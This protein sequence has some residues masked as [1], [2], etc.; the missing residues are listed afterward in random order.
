MEPTKAKRVRIYF[1]EDDRWQGRPLH[2]ALVEL[3]QAEHA[4][5]ATVL[6]GSEGFGAE[7][8]LHVSSLV[9]VAAQLPV[10]VEWIDTP[11]Q[12]QRLLPQVLERVQHGLV[13]V[14]E[15]ELV[16]FEPPTVHALRRTATVATVMSREVST[17]EPVTPIRRVVEL[18]LGRTY[19]AVPVTEA[20]KPVGIITNTDLVERGGLGVR[21][22]LLRSLDTPEVHEIL[23]RLSGQNRVASEV[24]TRSPTTVRE[25]TSLVAAADLMA[26]RRLKRLPVIDADRRLVGMVSRL[27]LLR[28]A[29]AELPPT[30]AEPYEMGLA[31]NERLATVMRRDVPTVN[32][33]T[34]LPEVF[35]AVIATRLHRAFVVDGDR[36]V[37][38]LVSDAQLLERVT[39]TLRRS[40]LR[41]LM[42]R[43]PFVHPKEEPVGAHARGRTA[44]DVMTR[45][46]A[47]VGED[48]LLSQAIARM[49]RDGQKVL[50]VTDPD[51]RLAGIVD[52]ADLLHGLIPAG[53]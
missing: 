42:S 8:R 33:D 47:Q 11:E 4:R 36:R 13:T 7:G 41:S 52:R 50:A 27:D 38:G 1:N 2:R 19:R 26:R 43:L 25:N 40:A 39:P 21:L 15:T 29:A 23:E 9:D 45:S 12:V 28:C 18:M 17:V 31:G 5:G 24:M 51:G 30:A 3:L 10:V 49:L 48:A 6:R 34:P 22:D 14:D 44:A 16:L 37:V 35:Q 32:P 53:A 46:F 20:G